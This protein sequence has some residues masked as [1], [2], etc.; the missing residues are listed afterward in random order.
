MKPRLLPTLRPFQEAVDFQRQRVPMTRAAF[1]R[2]SEEARLRA[3]TIAGLTKRSLLAEAY[4]LAYAASAEGLTKAEFATR[5]GAILDKQD[6]LVLT[7]RRI[8]LIAQNNTATSY[9]AG[10]YEQLSDP[11]VLAARPYWQYPLGPHDEQTSEIC[12]AL[13]GFVARYDAEEWKHVFPPNHHD[14]RHMNVRSLTEEQA[15]ASGKLYEGGGPKQYP[16]VDGREILPDPGFDYSPT[17]LGGDDRYLAEAARV[18][19]EPLPLKTWESYGLPSLREIVSAGELPKAPKRGAP[20]G[21]VSDPAEYASAWDRFQAALGF[22]GAATAIVD[23]LGEGV[24]VTRG[25]FEHLVGLDDPAEKLRK[26]T[27]PEFFSYLRP[28]IEDPIEIWMVATATGEGRVVWTRRYF[29]AFGSGKGFQ[30]FTAEQ[31]PQGWLA[32]SAYRKDLKGIDANRE[33]LLVYRR[34]G[35]S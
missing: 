13:E 11:E 24:L 2:L 12:L 6:G 27:A 31:S 18:A 25:T 28:T 3:F 9:A 22:D 5:L 14:E 15:R 23:A 21:D 34:G 35:R 29:A 16:F 8:D 4:Q 33:G 32:R 1:D 26:V 17:L 10:R 7:P 30:V 20:I 19:G